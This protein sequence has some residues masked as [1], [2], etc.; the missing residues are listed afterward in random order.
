[1]SFPID[2]VP[3]ISQ[4]KCPPYQNYDECFSL[5]FHGTIFDDT[6]LLE[7]IPGD[8]YGPV[9]Q[10]GHLKSEPDAVVFASRKSLFDSKIEVSKLS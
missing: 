10:Y 2:E 6:I 4:A 8:Q 9:G 7:Y 5:D 3:L 1:M